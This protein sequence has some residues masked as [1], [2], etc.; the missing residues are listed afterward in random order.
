MDRLTKF[1]RGRVLL[2]SSCGEIAGAQAGS[3]PAQGADHPGVRIIGP[4]S[5]PAVSKT[6]A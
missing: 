5:E 2:R 1:P 3:V 6:P 4:P